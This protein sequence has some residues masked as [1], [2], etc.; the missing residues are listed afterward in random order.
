M[1]T[2]ASA[3][4]TESNSSQATIPGVTMMNTEKPQMEALSMEP[5]FPK[6]SRVSKNG[7]ER[8]PKRK[9]SVTTTKAATMEHDDTV[10]EPE[11]VVTTGSLRK[12]SRGPQPEPDLISE[13]MNQHGK[14]RGR[15]ASTPGVVHVESQNTTTST[16]AYGSSKPAR[17][18]HGEVMAPGAL[19]V[20]V[21]EGFENSNSNVQ[22]Q[23]SRT[24]SRDASSKGKASTPDSMRPGAQAMSGTE[25]GEQDTAERRKDPRANVRRNDSAKKSKESTQPNEAAAVV[26]GTSSAQNEK[27]R[28]TD[29]DA[30][31]KRMED[32]ILEM[33]N[34]MATS[35]ESEPEQDLYGKRRRDEDKKGIIKSHN[36]NKPVMD[37]VPPEEAPSSGYM[38]TPYADR[39]IAGAPD[40]V[41]GSTL[42]GYGGAGFGGYGN[43]TDEGLAI[44][45]AIEEEEDLFFPAAIE[46]DPDAKPSILKNRRFRVYTFGGV[47]LLIVIL[48]G[49]IVGIFAGKGKGSNTYP[50]TESPTFSPSTSREGTYREQFEK[51]VG[52]T[53]LPE[54][55]T[56]GPYQ[57]TPH[58]MA[59]TWITS[60]DPLNLPADSPNLIQRYLLVLFYFMTT[61][62]GKRPWRSCNPPIGEE[63]ATCIFQKYQRE[64]DDT[65][66]YVNETKTRWLSGTHECSWVGIECDDAFITRVIDL[67]KFS[68]MHGRDR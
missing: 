38:I 12:V 40:L 6:K 3:K 8:K 58:E 66:T 15:A 23:T 24:V 47:F 53:A 39:G 41:H 34:K 1:T 17:V 27:E 21:F 18:S 56:Q 13:P 4:R 29:Y 10:M 67:C 55:V 45:L 31:K 59:A 25:M 5:R 65:E 2:D 7:K 51:I 14:T 33:E 36:E 49:G 63:G 44:A 46:Y 64:S 9:T 11:G 26:A 37:L 60:L 57:V 35:S 32:K 20:Q 42:A 48:V 30:Y 61:D 16:V 62:N 52:E 54:G 22:V 28:S 19:S 68:I 50:P 43:V